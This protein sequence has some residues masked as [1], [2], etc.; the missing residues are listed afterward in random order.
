MANYPRL[1]YPMNVVRKA[2]KFLRQPIVFDQNFGPEDKAAVIEAF[3]IANSFRDSHVYP[4]RGI[5]L[6]VLHRMRKLG[7]MGLTAARPKRM[8]S[9]R[10]KLTAGSNNLDQ[11]NDLGGCRVITDDNE[12]VQAIIR[13][14]HEDFR[15]VI[16]R[17]YPY[18]EKPKDDG[19]RSHHIVFDYVGQGRSAQYHGRRIELQ[20]RTRLQH[21]WATAVEA[22]GLFRDED[23]KHSEGNH[24]WLR[25]FA[26]MSAEFSHVEGCAVHP[27]MPCRSDR[28]REIRHLNSFLRATSTLEDLKNL[29]DYAANYIY[30]PGRFFLIHYGKDHRVRVESFNSAVVGANNLRGLEERI[31][32]GEET[33]KVVLV[34]VDKIDKLVETYPSYFGD[35]SLFV[36]NLKS[37]CDGRD[38]IEYSMIPQERVAVKKLIPGDPSRLRRRYSNWTD[39]INYVTRR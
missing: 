22:I 23:L 16:R 14:I 12:G 34:E 2:G 11:I 32:V 26:L 29:T 37:I 24:D 19:Y 4:M 9:I 6:S 36:R 5:R 28:V 15:H 3:T 38:A 7:V 30:D 18:I 25:L 33:S 35:V 21:S 27:T 8:S 10:R 1:Q 17:E 31:V 39:T 13:S 20:L